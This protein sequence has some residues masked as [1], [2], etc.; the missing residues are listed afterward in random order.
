ME[1]LLH[2]WVARRGTTHPLPVPTYLFRT[3]Q[4]SVNAAPHLGWDY[5]CP[6]LTVIPIPSKHLG[7][8]GS[9]N[10]PVL[11]AAFRKAVFQV[12]GRPVSERGAAVTPR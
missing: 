9:S 1:P 12:L 7:M 2:Q 3:E 5:Y 4:H 11:C 8:L 10:R 6:D